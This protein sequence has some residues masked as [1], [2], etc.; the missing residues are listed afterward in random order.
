MTAATR[1]V[2]FGQINVL[3]GDLWGQ[4]LHR[5]GFPFWPTRFTPEDLTIRPRDADA[6]TIRV[7]EA[8]SYRNRQVLS[9]ACLCDSSAQRDEML[10]NPRGLDPLSLSHEFVHL[11][12][13][14]CC[15]SQLRLTGVTGVDEFTALADATFVD[16]AVGAELLLRCLYAP[17]IVFRRQVKAICWD[18]PDDNLVTLRA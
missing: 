14:D 1:V 13:G 4:R 18:I 10:V 7:T 16:I 11:I 15:R 8:G 17:V 6:V 2:L 5:L 12:W 3:Q 9:A